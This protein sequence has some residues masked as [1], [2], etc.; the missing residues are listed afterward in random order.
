MMTEPG[1]TRGFV[2]YD[3]TMQDIKTREHHGPVRNTIRQIGLICKYQ[4]PGQM[5]IW[6]LSMV[7]FGFEKR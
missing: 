2:N 4:G 5:N 1:L 7:S 3:L 6:V